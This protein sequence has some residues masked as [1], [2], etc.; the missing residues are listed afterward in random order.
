MVTIGN[1]GLVRLPRPDLALSQA[2]SLRSIVS[3]YR[4]LLVLEGMILGDE[5]TSQGN[6]PKYFELALRHFG[7]LRIQKLSFIL[8]ISWTLGVVDKS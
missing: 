5:E 6:P 4:V 7:S 2:H 8:V 3:P 1:I